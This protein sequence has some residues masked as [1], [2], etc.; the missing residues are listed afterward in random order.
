LD[1]LDFWRKRES[2]EINDQQ[3]YEGEKSE[4]YPLKKQQANWYYIPIERRG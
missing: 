1:L 2:S 4:D 3:V